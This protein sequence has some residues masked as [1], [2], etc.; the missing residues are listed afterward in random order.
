MSLED[1]REALDFLMREGFLVQDQKG[2]WKVRDLML[3]TTN[4][5]HS[6]MM[7]K[8]HVELLTLGMKSLLEDSIDQ[9]SV[10]GLTLSIS[11]KQ[12][13]ELKARVLKFRQELN[14]LY[15]EEDAVGDDVFQVEIL[16]WPMTKEGKS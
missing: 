2:R 13:P 7:R 12:L 6:L 3:A 16:L 1:A 5:Q 14:Q 4:E 15:S 11:R 9:R 10:Q 8:L